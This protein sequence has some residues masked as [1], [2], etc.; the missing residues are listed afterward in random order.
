MTNKIDIKDNSWKLNELQAAE[1][2]YNNCLNVDDYKDNKYPS[3][4]YALYNLN[5]IKAFDKKIDTIE[6]EID[7]LKTLLETYEGANLDIFK[8]KTNLNEISSKINFIKKESDDNYQYF[9]EYLIDVAKKYDRLKNE[10]SKNVYYQ[11]SN[12]IIKRRIKYNLLCE[13]KF[14]IFFD[15]INQLKNNYNI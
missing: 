4:K 14:I 15:I 12:E 1:A 9:E 11:V 8:V 10:I 5:L 7:K 6:R 13:K 2:L 3:L